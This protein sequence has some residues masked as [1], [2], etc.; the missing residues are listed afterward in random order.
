MHTRTLL[1]SA[2]AAP[3][4]AMALTGCEGNNAN[5]MPEGIAL[6]SFNNCGQLRDYAEEVVL[7]Q[8]IMSRYGWGWYGMLEDDMGGDA[9][10]NESSGPDD[11]TTTNTQEAGVDEIDIVK[12]NG[13]HIFHAEGDKLQTVKSWPVDDAE[14]VSTLDMGEWIRGLFLYEDTILV[15]SWFYDEEEAFSDRYWGGTRFSFVDVSDPSNPEITRHIDIEGWLAD[16]RL[17]EENAYLVINTWLPIPQEAWELL[18]S[19]D[20]DLPEPNYE[21]EDEQDRIRDEARAILSPLVHA[22]VDDLEIADLVPL[23]RDQEIGAADADIE[24]LLECSDV[25]RPAET[26]QF[27]MSSIIRVDLEDHELDATAVMAD[28]WTVYASKD[29]LY[30]A[31]TSWWWWW[32]WGDLDLDTNIHKFELG[33]EPEY[34]AAGQVDGW[35]LN[36]FS[37]SEYDGYLRVASTETDWWWGTG[38]EQGGNH[39]TVLEDQNGELTEVGSIRDIAPGERIT[40]VRMMGDEGYVVTFEWIDPLWVVDLSDPEDPTLEGELEL[41]GFSTYLHPLGD[42]HLIAVGYAGTMAGDIT[43]MAVNLFDVSDKEN[44]A[45][46]DQYTLDSDDWS[47]SEALWDHHAFTYHREVLSIPVYTYDYDEFSGYWQGFSGLL[48]LKVTAEDG[49]E[50]IG[51]VNH[52]DLV[53]DS[54]CY[55]DYGCYD[56]YWYA[57]MRRSVYIEDNLFSISNYGMKVNELMDPDVE[58]AKVLYYPAAIP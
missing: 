8:L 22:I 54:D 43:G 30:L 37:M 25:Y 51:R 42:D 49:I 52:A 3:L 55:Y 40:G 18:W 13:T 36:Q 10:T 26:A 34:V 15:L 2:L 14:L 48:V 7:E 39:V 32:G 45:L 6:R 1:R 12:T 23:Y 20:V 33:D 17:I 56:D 9:P 16:G 38:E 21:D 44:P 27:S 29:N 35:L 4:L 11:Y 31:Q 28:G 19:E 50:E 57:W 46:Q 47:W 58:I 5:D 53:A 24:P 41:P